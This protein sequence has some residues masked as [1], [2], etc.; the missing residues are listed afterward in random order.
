MENFIKNLEQKLRENIQLSKIEILDNTHKHV[1]HKSFQK[2][3]YH[4]TLI[5]ESGEL[6]HLN[7]I[8]AHKRVIKVI[9]EEL[10]TK[11]HAVEI[12]IL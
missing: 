8:E 6:R 10:K 2:N 5:I 7:K 11:I 1:K 4:I 3:K 9:S 12:K